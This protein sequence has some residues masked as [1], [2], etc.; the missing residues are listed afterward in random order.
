MSTIQKS[1]IFTTLERNNLNILVVGIGGLGVVSLGRRLRDLMANRY[2]HVHTMEQ[3]GVTQRRAS[4]AAVVMAAEKEIAPRLNIAKTDLLIGLE[5]LETLR[6]SH[7]LRAGSWC[8][9][10]DS[11]IETIGGTRKY[12]YPDTHEIY[13][14]I[15][16][17]G[18]YC[19][20]LPL[21]RWRDSTG[22][23]PVHAS[24]V[25]LGLFCS[26]FGFNLNE[27]KSSVFG[28]YSARDK[29]KNIYALEWGFSQYPLEV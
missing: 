11:R 12:V 29:H 22:M 2:L 16:E 17:L 8:F 25:M 7:T 15:E 1:S 3:R 26:V 9:M 10:S 20:L 18:C 5:P 4:T 14:K 19:T 21:S 24:S 6:F 28:N 23:E 13:R 27:V